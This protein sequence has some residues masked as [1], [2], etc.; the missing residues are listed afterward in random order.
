[1]VL[2]SRAQLEVPFIYHKRK[3]KEKK[4][5]KGR[6]LPQGSTQKKPKDYGIMARQ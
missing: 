4:V 1:M 6:R 5:R 3:K 2:S